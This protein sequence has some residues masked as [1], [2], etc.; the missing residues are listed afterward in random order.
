MIK[1]NDGKTSDW[2][3][4][5]KPRIL[6]PNTCQKIDQHSKGTGIDTN[7]N[8]Q[9]NSHG[10][11]PQKCKKVNTN[12]LHT[13]LSKRLLVALVLDLILLP[14]LRYLFFFNFLLLCLVHDDFVRGRNEPA[15]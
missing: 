7:A 14:D 8:T 6:H 15:S 5:K 11:A 9:K 13:F 10:K 1:A 2:K 12:L 3:Q 4:V